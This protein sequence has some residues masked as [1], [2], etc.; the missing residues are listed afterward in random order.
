MTVNSAGIYQMELDGRVLGKFG[1][2][3][4]LIKEFGTVNAM[5]CRR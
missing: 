5:D 2:A 3:G 1:R 4:K